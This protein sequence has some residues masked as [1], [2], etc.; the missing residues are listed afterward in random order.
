MRRPI[1]ISS[2]I[3]IAGLMLAGCNF[4]ARGGP[5]PTATITSEDIME[6]A[7]AIAEATRQGITPTGTQVAATA[8]PSAEPVTQVPTVTPT[9]SSPIV[10][11]DY[12][13]NV[14]T[15][16]GEEFPA[17]D[18]LLEGDQ[19]NAVGQFLND[20]TGT[21]YFLR[22]IGQGLDG[23]IWGGAVTVAGDPNLIPFIESPPTP[24]PGPSPTPTEDGS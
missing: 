9:P 19:A 22:R 10:I 20:D 5:S 16:P 13:A 21:W 6:T 15:G 8:T 18:F 3:L 24:T 23:W 2:L 14:R 12:N 11:A 7:Q 4:G 17:I 1:T